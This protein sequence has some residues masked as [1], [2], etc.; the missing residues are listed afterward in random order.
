MW[1]RDELDFQVRYCLVASLGIN[2]KCVYTKYWQVFVSFVFLCVSLN[3]SG[4]IL[5]SCLFCLTTKGAKEL[6]CNPSTE[7]RKRKPKLSS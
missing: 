4:Q 6:D 3:H 2:K 1:R 7:T 5:P